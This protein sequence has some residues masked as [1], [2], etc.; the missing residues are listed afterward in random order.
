MLGNLE[1]FNRTHNCGKLSIENEN[2]NVTIM[3]W[4]QKRR[5]HGG[6][7]FIDVRDRSGF[8]Q[9]VFNPDLNQEAFKKAEELRSEFVVAIKG[10][11][12]K[13]P[14]GNINDELPT[15]RIEIEGNELRILDKAETTPFLINNEVNPGEDLRLKYR[16]LDLRRPMMRDMM[17]LRHKTVKTTRDFLDNKDFWEIETPL[18]TKST[19]E[20]ARDYLVPSRINPGQFY[21][22]PQ[23]PQLF[24]QLLMISG[25]ERYFQIA[26]CFRDEDLRAN[27]QPEFTQIDIEMSFVTR[28]DIFELT[29]NLLRKIFALNDI[30]V[31]QEVPVMTYQ[32]A[33]DQ[34]GLDKP[35]LRFDM[36]LK[37]ISD[38]VQDSEFNIFSGTVKKGG[39]VKGIKVKNGTNFSRSQIDELED[40]VKLYGAKGLAWI[41]FENGEINSPIAKFLSDE[42]LEKII[43]KMEAQS[44]DLMLFVADKPKV[45]ANSLGHLRVKLGKELDLIDK[46][47]YKFT[48]IVDFPMFE[49][50]EEEERYVA[51][52]HPFTSP[53]PEDI[54]KL[55]N[56]LENLKA[57]SYD[58]VLNG[59]E[60][61]G[62]SIRINNKKLQHR[63]FDAMNFTEDE[64]QNKF[65]FLMDA[66][67]YGT[68]P[69]GGIALGLDR[70][71]MILGNTDSIRN[72]IAFPKTQKATSPLTDAPSAVEQKQLE[73]LHINLIN[74]D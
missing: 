8:V 57:N 33:I 70:I 30:E 11:V 17:E 51:K 26:K 4:V 40:F 18:L 16:Y 62:G 27:R 47:D 9:V 13:R 7:I 46:D 69:H 66:F 48:W 1:G 53:L 34:Y 43:E 38:I 68:P 63:V 23:S 39:Q 14:S 3:G 21:A 56:D 28:E 20:G 19:P 74:L 41:K 2:D 5:D 32:E 15:G 37:N 12:R 49:Y 44:G 64:I 73:E 29:E 6:V 52:H 58:I 55:D 59:E 67:E 50:N 24:K 35:D 72:V 25:M 36:K 71:I 42:E 31:P 61:G 65:G 10:S 60:L 22:L 54:D 45:V